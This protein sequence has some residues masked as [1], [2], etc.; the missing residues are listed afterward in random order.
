MK[1]V[2][3][4]Y[5]VLGLAAVLGASTVAHLRNPGFFYAVVPPALCTDAGSRCGVMSRDEWV[6][7]SAIPEA[8]AAVGLLIPAT[9]KV[10]AT[11][12]AVMFGAF[13]AGHITALQRAFGLGGTPRGRLI[14]A[15][16]LPLQVPLILWAWRL[17]RA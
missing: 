15:V 6:A 14:H 17:R 4:N 7:L 5:P 16:R 2:R 11:A 3:I 13:T 10:A 12:T 1:T 9:R 8:A